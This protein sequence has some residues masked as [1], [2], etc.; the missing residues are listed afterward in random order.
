MN[1]SNIVK[2]SPLPK[3]NNKENKYLEK[4]LKPENN[5]QHNFGFFE[6]VMGIAGSF[7]ISNF[8]MKMS[9]QENMLYNTSNLFVLFLSVMSFNTFIISCARPDSIKTIMLDQENIEKGKKVYK[10]CEVCHGTPG[11]NKPPIIGPDLYG[12]VGKKIASEKDF[13]YSD[14]LKK[15]KEKK[16]TRG[17]LDIWLNNPLKYAP[18]TKMIFPGLKKKEDREAVIEYLQSIY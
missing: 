8:F 6:T 9:Y 18:G 11:K 14:A 2:D 13:E 17:N 7:G 5:D 3:L 4:M 10:K 15:L 1:I 16:W 12:I